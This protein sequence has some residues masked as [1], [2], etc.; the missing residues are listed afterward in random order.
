MSTARRRQLIALAE[1]YNV[2]LVED[3]FAAEL[4][5]DG[6]MQPALKA[7]DS[8]GQVIYIGSFSKMLMPGLRVG[9]LVAEGPI[10]QQLTQF[11]RVNDLMTSTLTQRALDLYV[12]VGRYQAHVRRSS[13]A[14]RKRRD[15]LAQAI[16]ELLPAECS[17]NLPQGGLFLWLR[18]PEGIAA[19]ALYTQALQE[20][21]QF[22]PGPR[23]FAQPEQGESFLRL[24]FAAVPQ[25]RIYEGIRRLQRAINRLA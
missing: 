15:L 4:R 25:E 1:R 24:N 19:R 20:G 14:Y 23:F 22:A 6:R 10:Y 9:F 2:A 7:F 17:Y 5:Y 8:G 16:D 13:Q 3:D 18:L 12:T 21:V 11:K